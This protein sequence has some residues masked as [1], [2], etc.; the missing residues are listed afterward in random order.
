MPAF[1]TSVN[2]NN[3]NQQQQQQQ[4]AYVNKRVFVRLE[5][6]RQVDWA[7]TAKETLDRVLRA[8]LN[9]NVA[10]NVILFIGDGMG[11]ATVTAARIYAAQQRGL[12]YGEESALSFEQFPHVGLAKVKYTVQVQR[13]NIVNQRNFYHQ[14]AH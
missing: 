14:G 4:Q 7:S 13:H 1:Q 2:N 11:V 9:T 10:R 3:N 8:Q 12:R 5:E 6:E